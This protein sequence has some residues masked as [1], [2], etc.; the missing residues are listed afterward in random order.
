MLDDVTGLA[1]G[2]H[3]FVKFLTTCRKLGYSVLYIFHEPTLSSPRWKDI[4]SNMHMFCVFS[5]AMD[6]VLN[7][8]R[9]FIS[10]SPNV[11][12]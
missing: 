5:S 8:F 1:D 2:S 10:R 3:S 12:G 11:K 6:L 7:H 4:L 9:Q